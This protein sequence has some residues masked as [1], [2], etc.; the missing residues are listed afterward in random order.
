MIDWAV[1]YLGLLFTHNSISI[2]VE[3]HVG[4]DLKD[5]DTETKTEVKVKL[6]PETSIS[7]YVTYLVLNL[8]SILV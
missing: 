5:V 8:Q 7:K 2:N 3:F 4:N 1:F 6:Y